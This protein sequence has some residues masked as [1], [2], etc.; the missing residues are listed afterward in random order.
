LIRTGTSS[1]PDRR[2]GAET[3]RLR[4]DPR[5]GGSRRLLALILA[6]ALGTL[7]LAAARPR[8]ALADEVHAFAEL[9]DERAVAKAH[10]ELGRKY[11]DARAYEKAIIEYQA[12]Y[13]VSPMPELLFNIGQCYRLGGQPRSAVLYYQRYLQLVSEGGASDEARAHVIALRQEIAAHPQ[14][15]GVA[16]GP[17][18]SLAGSEAAPPR[19]WR[20]FGAGSIVAGLALGGVSLA[21][22]SSGDDSD[23]EAIALTSVG[24]ALVAAGGVTWWLSSRMDAPRRLVAAPVAGPGLAGVAFGGTF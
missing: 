8:A 3:I 11:Q 21:M 13:A 2:S 6:G 5:T 7:P 23:T 17:P 19:D 9:D 16:I 1:G 10:F 12:A 22:A 24:A 4:N 15:A 14:V 18:G 20:W